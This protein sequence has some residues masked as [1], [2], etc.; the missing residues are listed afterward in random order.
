MEKEIQ[1]KKVTKNR[2]P[3]QLLLGLGLDAFC[4]GEIQLNIKFHLGP[5]P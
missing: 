1:S 3:K 2:P 5:I 4:I